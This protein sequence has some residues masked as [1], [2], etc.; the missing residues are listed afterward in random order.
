MLPVRSAP[1]MALRS[2]R[3]LAGARNGA[4]A[5]TRA[6]SQGRILRRRIGR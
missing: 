6:K 4:A 2:L 5:C 1:S 3:L